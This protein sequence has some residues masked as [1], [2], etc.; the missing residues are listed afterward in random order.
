MKATKWESIPPAERCKKHGRHCRYVCV[1]CR[2]QSAHVQGVQ[3]P[4]MFTWVA[5]YAYGPKV[6]LDRRR[7][8]A[9]EGSVFPDGQIALQWLTG[10]DPSAVEVY[11][12]MRVLVAKH[13]VDFEV[14]RRE[15]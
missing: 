5:L 10:P 12:S 8:R 14:I 6:R 7:M 13:G 2:T 1:R 4:P 3:P 15:V 9:A 11:P